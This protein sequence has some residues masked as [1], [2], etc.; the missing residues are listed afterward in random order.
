MTGKNSS[1]NIDNLARNENTQ[2]TQ[3][4]APESVPKKS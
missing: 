3:I 2:V 4:P 1:A